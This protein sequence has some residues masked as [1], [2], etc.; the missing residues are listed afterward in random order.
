M[1]GSC[2]QPNTHQSTILVLAFAALRNQAG[3]QRPGASVG[4]PLFAGAAPSALEASLMAK[5][6]CTRAAGPPGSLFQ[7]DAFDL[8]PSWAQPPRGRRSAPSI[9]LPDFLDAHIASELTGLSG[10]GSLR[11]AP[12]LPLRVPARSLHPASTRAASFTA[13]QSALPVARPGRC[14]SV[15]ARLLRGPFQS[16]AA[17]PPPAQPRSTTEWCTAAWRP[18]RRRRGERRRPALAKQ[19]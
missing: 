19:F 13:E 11:L 4:R 2:K 16:P 18:W 5:R 9:A 8:L 15:A 12:P 6:G 7:L 14:P 17:R 1:H 3:R 10:S